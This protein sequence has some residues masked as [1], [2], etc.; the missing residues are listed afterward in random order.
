VQRGA[1]GVRQGPVA[2]ADHAG[3]QQVK[4]V[5]GRWWG[6]AAK[7][8]SLEPGQ[9]VGREPYDLLFGE[10]KAPDGTPLGRP[11]TVYRRR[12]GRSPAS[13]CLCSSRSF[14]DL[15]LGLAADLLTNARPGRAKAEIYRP[16]I[17]V[18]G[19]VPVDG[20]LAVPA[21]LARSVRRNRRISRWLPTQCVQRCKQPLTW[22]ARQDSNPRPAA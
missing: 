1:A 4:A 20:V 2:D 19:C 16:D 5:D 6:S 17:P 11:P 7:A 15:G 22:C 3:R 9:V 13:T 12:R 8:L 21:T 10:R 18:Q 14:A